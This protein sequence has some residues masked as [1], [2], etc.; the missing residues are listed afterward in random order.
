MTRR[1]LTAVLVLVAAVGGCSTSSGPD[2]AE[3]P[4]HPDIPGLVVFYQFD[5]DLQNEVADEHH[6]TSGRAVT[7]IADHNGTPDSAVHVAG[8]TLWVSDHPDL[9]VT[10]AITLAAWVRPDISNH[11]YAAV[12]DKNYDEAYS[13]GMHGAADP[14]TVHIRAYLTDVDFHTG[15][16]VPMGTSTWSHIAFT[17]DEGTD[18]A[19]FYFNGSCVETLVSPVAIGTC[20]KNLRIGRAYYGDRY[21]GGV[22]QAAVFDR[23]LTPAEVHA[24]YGFD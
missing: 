23:A 18:E 12:I 19:R 4:G 14:D 2:G 1:S 21:S 8:D 22:D 5:G 7:Y 17:F 24:L 6:L 20:D 15:D 11:C 16:M 9:D 3:D 13:L 10:G